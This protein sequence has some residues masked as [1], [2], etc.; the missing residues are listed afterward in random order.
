M[1]SSCIFNKPPVKCGINNL[2]L[3]SIFFMSC[4]WQYDIVRTYEAR[5]KAGP[6]TVASGKVIIAYL[7][8]ISPNARRVCRTGGIIN[9]G[10]TM[11]PISLQR[12][13]NFYYYK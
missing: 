2:L 11:I 8:F 4:K 13:A 1:N 12:A 3:E 7:L 9:P 6:A 10:E 5:L